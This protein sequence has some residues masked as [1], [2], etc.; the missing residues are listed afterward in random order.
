VSLSSPPPQGHAVTAN[1]GIVAHVDA[2]KTSLTE[3]LLF[4]AGAID[5][6][7]SVDAG[8]SLTDSMEVERRRGITVR[9]NVAS[10][11]LAGTGEGPH[12]HVNLIDTL[13]TQTSLPRSSGVCRCWM[14]RCSW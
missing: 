13:V 14:P 5:A 11:L 8:T 9:T 12:T 7:G 1:W 3:R 10:F 2:G 6:L 4:E